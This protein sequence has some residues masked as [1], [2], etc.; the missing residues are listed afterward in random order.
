M[1][2][3]GVPRSRNEPLLDQGQRRCCWQCAG[4]DNVQTRHP[5]ALDMFQLVQAL[6]DPLLDSSPVAGALG[7]RGSQFV[8]GKRR[9]WSLALRS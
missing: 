7:A 5:E 9:G 1:A 6:L 2:T 4:D 3:Q 8:S